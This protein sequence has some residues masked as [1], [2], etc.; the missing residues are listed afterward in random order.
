MCVNM[1]DNSGLSA[2]TNYHS[3]T[4]WLDGNN[5]ETLIFSCLLCEADVTTVIDPSSDR[6]QAIEKWNMWTKPERSL[7]EEKWMCSL[8]VDKQYPVMASV[9]VLLNV[10][11]VARN[12]TQ[13]NRECTYRMM[14]SRCDYLY[15]IWR[16]KGIGRNVGW[17]RMHSNF[18]TKWHNVHPGNLVL[19]VHV[20]DGDRS[21]A[22][23]ERNTSS[24]S[25]KWTRVLGMEMTTNWT[26]PE[27]YDEIDEIER[28]VS[29]NN[30]PEVVCSEREQD[31]NGVSVRPVTSS[32]KK[33]R[34][35]HN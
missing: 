32:R 14:M 31:E 11:W 7:R 4:L 10:S 2:N 5:Q 12:A 1:D 34:N 27:F 25:R 20:M 16:T 15:G 29:R 3:G 9:R 33:K 19:S 23:Y 28:T 18:I 13:E 6:A 17:E 22:D 21:I 30:T 35:E 24:I 8:V 26:K